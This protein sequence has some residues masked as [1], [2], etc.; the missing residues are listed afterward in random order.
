[1]S[2]RDHNIIDNMIDD[3]LM[4][5]YIRILNLSNGRSERAHRS[6]WIYFLNKTQEIC[7]A[8]FYRAIEKKNKDIRQ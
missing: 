8:Q 7:R 1:M 6:M 5:C 3:V 4:D 2:K